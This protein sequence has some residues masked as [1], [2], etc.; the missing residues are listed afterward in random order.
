MKKLFSVLVLL[1][2]LALPAMSQGGGALKRQGPDIETWKSVYITRR[3]NL[4]TEEA[5][6]FWPIYNAYSA[7][8]HQAYFNYRSN[9]NEIQLDESLLN[10]RKKYSVEFTRALSFGKV[11]DFFRAEKDFN[12]LVLKEQQRR[13]L[14]R[15]PFPGP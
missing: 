8:V 7:E 11:N 12:V 10:I 14:Q 6:K 13:Q 15:R 9:N 4:T 1:S 2:C 3:L 5:Q